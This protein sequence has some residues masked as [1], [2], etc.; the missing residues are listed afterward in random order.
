[1]RPPPC[2]GTAAWRCWMSALMANISMAAWR[3]S[4]NDLREHPDGPASGKMVWQSAYPR[5]MEK[6]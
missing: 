4:E 2:P 6:V 1:M 3:A 5:E